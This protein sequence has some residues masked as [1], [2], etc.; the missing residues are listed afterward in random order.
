[1]TLLWRGYYDN[2]LTFRKDYEKRFGVPPYVHPVIADCWCEKEPSHSPN[3]ECATKILHAQAAGRENHPSSLGQRPQAQVGLRQMARGKRTRH[4]I[5]GRDG[6]SSRRLRAVLPR[7]LQSVSAINPEPNPSTKLPHTISKADLPP[8]QRPERT[9]P[10]LRLAPKRGPSSQPRWRP[11]CCRPGFVMLT[12]NPVVSKPKKEERILTAKPPTS[13]G[14]SR[15]T[16][17]NHGGYAGPPS[18]NLPH[19]LSR[20]VSHANNPR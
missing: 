3:L 18:G 9:I 13:S 6:T 17:Q 5:Q 11:E 10:S 20:S 8:W 12:H 16:V 1:M 14:P 7:C 15:P 2:F 19:E 4:R